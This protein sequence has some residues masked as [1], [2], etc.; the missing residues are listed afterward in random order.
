MYHNNNNVQQDIA[1]DPY[2]SDEALTLSNEPDAP[3]SYYCYAHSTTT[4][5]SRLSS[6][7]TSQSSGRRLIEMLLCSRGI[8]VKFSF[9]NS[10]G[11]IHSLRIHSL[12]IRSKPKPYSRPEPTRAEANSKKI[13]QS[14]ASLGSRVLAVSKP[15]HHVG[16]FQKPV[17]PPQWS[18]S[19][20]ARCS[21]ADIIILLQKMK[22]I[23]EMLHL[24]RRTTSPQR[25]QI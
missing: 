21:L 12:K 17:C 10:A 1:T 5:R 7:R 24:Q 23:A 3:K 11:S 9:S 4:L 22:T 15:R 20:P 19:L 14:I 13:S 25:L 2:V 18:V 8:S 16:G 6:H